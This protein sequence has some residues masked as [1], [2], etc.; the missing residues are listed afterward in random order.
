[1]LV[2]FKENLAEKKRGLEWKEVFTV[3]RFGIN[4]ATAWSSYSCLQQSL[5]VP[6][7][8]PI[9]YDNKH[10]TWNIREDMLNHT[11]TW[12]QCWKCRLQKNLVG[13]WQLAICAHT[14]ERTRVRRCLHIGQVKVCIWVHMVRRHKSVVFLCGI[15]SIK[16]DT[17]TQEH[18]SN[19]TP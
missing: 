7:W 1:M 16:V 3:T 4:V 15:N 13:I 8:T 9:S 2:C 14:G 10:L 12:N 18:C 5:L 6:I 19:N 17:Q 11:N